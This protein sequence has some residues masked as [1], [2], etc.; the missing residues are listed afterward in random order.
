MSFTLDAQLAADTLSLGQIDF[1]DIRLMKDARYVWLVL[2]PCID[3]AVEWHD[4]PTGKGGALH[5]IAMRC[6][7]ALQKMTQAYKMNIAA[8][9][10]MVRQL[11]VHVIAR[12]EGDTAWPG[13]V[14]GVGTA[15]SHAPQA[16]GEICDRLKAALAL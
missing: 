5:D 7:A 9:G 13:P 3:G 4:L 1:V 16:Q 12:H 15:Q 11:H 8:L 2:V 6:A 10:N 14:W